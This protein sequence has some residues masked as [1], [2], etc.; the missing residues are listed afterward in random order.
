VHFQSENTIF[1]S[2]QL[3][4]NAEFRTTSRWIKTLAI[5]LKQ[6]AFRLSR[7]E[8][9]ILSSVDFVL[10]VAIVSIGSV[11]GLATV[12]DQVVQQFG[13]IAV[14]MENLEQTYTVNITYS[15]GST[16]QF[17]FTDGASPVDNADQA[18]GGI[19]IAVPADNE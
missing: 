10:F 18:P 16:E 12:R 4:G 13:D 3:D 14:A 19:E 2:I 1:K 17:G 9:G 7:D 5:R 6:L 8:I 11:V 15:N